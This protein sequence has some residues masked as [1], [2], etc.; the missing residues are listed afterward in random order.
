[1]QELGSCQHSQ[2]ACP[3]VGHESKSKHTHQLWL[4]DFWRVSVSKW[5]VVFLAHSLRS[6]E[7]YLAIHC[8]DHSERSEHIK[9]GY[10]CGQLWK[11]LLFSPPMWHL[12]IYIYVQY[13]DTGC[14]DVSCDSRKLSIDHV[15]ITM[16]G[17]AFTHF[18]CSSACQCTIS[19]S[20][21]S[22]MC[23]WN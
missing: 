17:R 21:T 5:C 18:H 23:D 6:F 13:E 8:F 1:M 15:M 10:L 11:C 12:I 19:C 9:K 2:F 14:L 3:R 4:F 16:F 22:S 20:D 7:I